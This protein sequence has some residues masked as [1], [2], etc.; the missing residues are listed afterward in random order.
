MFVFFLF[1]EMVLC[2]YF[3]NVMFKVA[4]EINFFM[5]I[6]LFIFCLLGLWLKFLLNFKS[7]LV[8]LFIVEIIIMI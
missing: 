2:L 4:F 8:L 3:F 1:K 6:I 7:L 5:F